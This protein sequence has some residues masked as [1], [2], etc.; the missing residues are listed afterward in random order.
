MLTGMFAFFGKT[1]TGQVVFLDCTMDFRI[2]FDITIIAYLN[3]GCD[4]YT[5]HMESLSIL[6]VSHIHICA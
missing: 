6:Y 5:T 2:D 1:S 3:Y 4:D